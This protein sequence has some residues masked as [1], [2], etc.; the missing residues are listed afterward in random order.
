[1]PKPCHGNFENARA[2][3]LILTSLDFNSEIAL[4]LKGSSRWMYAT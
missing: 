1:M 4:M 2:S 3:E